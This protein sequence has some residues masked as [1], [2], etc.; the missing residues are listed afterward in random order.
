MKEL[1][2]SSGNGTKYQSDPWIT[3]LST[4]IFTA[5]VVYAFYLAPL[6]GVWLVFLLMLAVGFLLLLKMP[7]VNHTADRLGIWLIFLFVIFSIVWPRYA[8]L[9]VPGSPGLSPPRLL[10]GM[11]TVYWLYIVSKNFSYR[12]ILVS[13]IK[14]S[15]PFFIAVG[16]LLLFKFF[17]VF[18]SDLP[19]VSLKGFFNELLSVYFLILV[20]L[21]FVRDINDVRIVLFAFL[22]GSMGAVGV[23]IVEYALN[24][25]VFI[26]FLDVDSD[27]MKQVF[28]EKIRAGSYRLQST[29]SHPLT[30]SE[31]M[32]VSTPVGVVLLRKLLR[33][34]ILFFFVFLLSISACTLVVIKSGSR[35][36]V[37]ALLLGVGL[38][39]VLC[40][41]RQLIVSRD[42]V[43]S[44]FNIFF[45]LTCIVALVLGLYFISDILVGK[46]TRELNSAL[47]R[48][49]MWSRGIQMALDQ[50]LFGYG[51]D[52]AA[53]T[54][55]FVEGD[56]NITIDSYY[57]SVLLEAGIIGFVCYLFLILYALFKGLS[58][59]FCE[60]ENSLFLI[61]ISVSIICFAVV[62]SVLSLTHNH[63]VFMIMFSLIFVISSSRFGKIME[64]HK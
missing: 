58:R 20:S 2:F 38:Y 5:F 48:L 12:S 42:R 16:L 59:G 18:S 35:S 51:Q 19:F 43:S 45:I 36:G 62:K 31:F 55:G 23:G 27:Y 47:V 11:L 30:F 25:N 3:Y 21:T 6:F 9:R 64:G 17:S 49:E 26:G 22:V 10:Q 61:A 57:L 60:D 33:N 29:F 53:I 15:R 32:V 7:A 40:S 44:V 50:P 37:G 28:A 14:E 41:A 13:R 24:K 54:L 39:F 34:N 52:M 8:L 4:S 1:L 46:T 63:G 56:G